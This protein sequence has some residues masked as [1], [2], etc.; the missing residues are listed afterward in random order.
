MR[1]TNQQK[2]AFS[3]TSH[4]RQAVTRASLLPPPALRPPVSRAIF[5]R[6]L[7]LLTV[8]ET[9][10]DPSLVHTKPVPANQS[11]PMTDIWL[12]ALVAGRRLHHAILVLNEQ[13]LFAL[14]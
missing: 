8:D 1:I 3:P 4:G 14:L 9:D 11:R 12:P 7:S 5:N 2:P 13:V 10:I 6:Q